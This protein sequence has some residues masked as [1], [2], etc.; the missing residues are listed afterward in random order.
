M[1]MLSKSHLHRSLAVAAAA[2]LS[3]LGLSA[4][5]LFVIS[6]PPASAS[7]PCGNNGVFSVNGSN[8]ATC[9]YQTLGADTFTV[10][11]N[12]GTT[13]VSV[14]V[15]GAGGAGGISTANGPGTPVPGGSGAKVTNA[16]LAATAG[17]VLNVEVGGGG[18]PGSSSSGG[19]ASSSVNAG[20]GN[21]IIAGAGG[22]AGEDYAGGDAGAQGA[23]PP[24]CVDGGG[25]PG[26]GGTGGVA[27]SSS[28]CPSGSTPPHSGG[29]GDGG[30]GGAGIEGGSVDGAGGAGAG[31]GTGGSSSDFSGAG[32]GG[33]GGGAG[34]YGGGGGGGGGSTGG[35][36]TLAGNGG[37]SGTS[38]S[39]F[40]GG[41]GGNGEVT[42]SYQI[43]PAPTNGTPPTISG[44]GNPGQSLTCNTADA[45]WNG[46]GPPFEFRYEF[47]N[48]ATVLQGPSQTQSTY[49]LTDPNAG[50]TIT[51]SVSASNVGGPSPFVVS[52]NSIPVTAPLSITAPSPS[53]DY[54][55]SIPTLTPQYTGLVNGDLA[56]TTP[57]TCVVTPPS[58][59]QA[60][61]YPV[62]CSGA[63]DPDYTISYVAGSLTIGAVPLTITAP[64]PTINYGDPVP[65]LTPQYAGLVNG[66]LTTTTPPTCTTTPASPTQAGTYPVN[67]SG[68]VDTNYSIS[69]VAGTL[70]INK[71]PL[72]I[73]APSAMV[74]SGQSPSLVPQYTGFVAGDG[75]SSLTTPPTCSSTYV[76]T[77]FPLPLP[78]SYPVT[79]TGAVDNNYT[80]SYVAGTFTVYEHAIPGAVVLAG[81]D[82]GVF[83]LGNPGGFHGSLPGL[84]I[85]VNDIVGI[86]ATPADNGYYLVGK[87]GGVFTFNTPF[88]GSLPGLELSV[89]DIVGI[90]P[91]PD[92]KG[93]YLVGKD[94]G[95]F[96]FGDAHY[97]G[98]LPGQGLSVSDVVGIAL[99]PDG[100]G[101]WLAEASGAVS[102]FGDAAPLGN[103][104]GGGIVSITATQGGSGYWLTSAS[105]GV[106]TYGD[107]PYQGSIPGLGLTVNNIVTL[108]PSP[109][110]GGYLV[111]GGDGGT[112]AFPNEVYSG[113]LAGMGLTFVGAA[114]TG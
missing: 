27:A 69:Y 5:S 57:P 6:S 31:S 78:G 99:T 74:L 45:D 56:T 15:I 72:T 24:G 83:A 92:N 21:Q 84:G 29:N 65:A 88:L 103:A 91:T 107:A 42:I 58:P 82:G 114:S 7:I 109:N 1:S 64:S 111:V 20:A 108:V 36:V 86:A 46:F 95:V 90:V 32:G 79:C 14:V 110:G 16:T 60:G 89:D 51:C 47:L 28:T 52:S 54:G 12:D 37:A 39:Q 50:E 35:G 49:L 96:T 102:H 76:P 17:D 62:N 75:P 106:F 70:T 25:L 26:G 59:T 61:N 67:C 55:D 77:A 2:C 23:N 10:P 30:A 43:P 80:I 34:G 85:H 63:I 44:T 98:S 87:D 13:S 48:G 22:G 18:Q 33:Y 19:G 3:S 11:P 41:P 38:H 68:A 93:Y 112:F 9:T 113:S 66:D 40:P 53:I 94:G 104:P 101:Y 97:R 71:V 105:G 4:G 73:T 100:G 8:L 81:P